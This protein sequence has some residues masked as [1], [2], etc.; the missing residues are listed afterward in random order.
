MFGIAVWVTNWFTWLADGLALR[1]TVFAA[2]LIC[3]VPSAQILFPWARNSLFERA[4]VDVVVESEPPPH[5]VAIDPTASAAAA[6]ANE[7]FFTDDLLGAGLES[8]HPTGVDGGGQ[9]GTL[10]SERH[11]YRQPSVRC[12]RQGS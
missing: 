5:P 12:G 6:A 9:T 8:R 4:A 1:N 11:R 7:L 3:L 10:S 2:W